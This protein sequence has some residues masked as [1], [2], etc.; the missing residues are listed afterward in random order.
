[1]GIRVGIDLGTTFSAVAWINPKTNQP[2]I[3]RSDSESERLITPSEIWFAPDQ[4][5]Y[6]GARAKD[7]FEAGEDGVA[8][9]F[10]RYMDTDE[11]C[12]FPPDGKEY[13]AEE[14]STILL[15]HLKTQAEKNC[16]QTID[17]AVITVP[18]YF[19]NE[20]RSATRRAAQKAGLCVNDIISEP[21]AAALNYGLEHWRENALIMVYDLGGG[22]FDVTLVAM[23]DNTTLTTLG[24]TGDQRRGGRDWDEELSRLVLGKVEAELGKVLSD[25][26]E[27]INDIRSQAEEWKKQLSQ[28]ETLRLRIRIP[29]SGYIMIQLTRK[30]FDEATAGLLGQTA[31]LCKRLL[32]DLQVNLDQITDVL[33]VGGSTRMP[34]VS[35]ILT[36]LRH[37]REPIMHVNPDYAVALGA[38]M[39]ANMQQ[40]EQ[41]LNLTSR[42]AA[43]EVVKKRT[44]DLLQTLNSNIKGSRTVELNEIR[45]QDAVAHAMGIVLVNPEKTGYI[46]SVVIPANAPAPCKFSKPTQFDSWEKEMEIYVLQGGESIAN[47]RVHAKYVVSGFTRVLE[48]MCVAHVQYS[49]DSNHMIHVQVRQDNEQTDLP[50][51]KEAFTQEDLKTFLG[52]YIPPEPSTVAMQMTIVLAIDVSGSM[53]G[54]P[55]T[56]AK[57]AMIDFTKKFADLDVSFGVLLVS[58]RCRW[59]IHPSNDLS[60]VQA[61]IQGVRVG[62]TGYG[63]EAHPFHDILYELKNDDAPRY[64]IVL[65]DGM[66]NDQQSAIVAAREC[67][68]QAIDIIGMG[69]GSADETFMRSISST[70]AVM[71]TD[72]QLGASFG[73]IAQSL[74]AGTMPANAAEGRRSLGLFRKKEMAKE[75]EPRSWNTPTECPGRI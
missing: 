46:N 75:L 53:S 55:I 70:D 61:A 23:T 8:N 34:Q 1:M 59:A 30:E 7:A 62:E 37:G 13:N 64:A 71:T 72:S 47:A 5:I 50:L 17:E 12:F 21:T 11:T 6:C 52:P 26:Q 39:R 22:T 19:E 18:A 35:R 41:V 10:K 32:Y 57:D 14:L 68:R 73:K 48:R 42:E 31:S 27:I 65:A 44:A 45:F 51:C 16:G 69:F 29:G 2:E 25:D 74:G 4:K 36:E 3:I 15:R 60:A 56:N 49:Y 67:H 63:N 38:A 33:L 9:T 54:N 40:R 43:A 58:D 24:T 28:V 20:P 66:W